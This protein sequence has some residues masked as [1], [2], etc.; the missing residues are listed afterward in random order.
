[1]AAILIAATAVVLS[2]CGMDTIVSDA[3]NESILNTATA[4]TAAEECFAKL[5]IASGEDLEALARQNGLCGNW[6]TLGATDEELSVWSYNDWNTTWLMRIDAS[7]EDPV[8]TVMTEG[9]A[10]VGV[11][12][13]QEQHTVVVCWQITLDHSGGKPDVTAFDCP[14]QW[15]ASMGGSEVMTIAELKDAASKLGVALTF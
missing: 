11:G 15:Y 10:R 2:G 6:L 4:I 14:E 8:I 7:T 3:R 1:V 5:E 12:V 13:Q 9:D